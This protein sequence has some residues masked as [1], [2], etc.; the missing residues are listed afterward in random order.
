MTIRIF[1][2]LLL[3]QFIAGNL[4]AQN[5]SVYFSDGE[6]DKEPSREVI[7]KPTI[8]MGIGMFSFYGDI[9]DK[10][11]NHA[12]VSK[13]GYDLNVGKPLTSFL[14]I[15]FYILFGTLSSN[16]RSPE[17]NLNFQS[18]IRTGGAI[19]SY[20]FDHLLRKERKVEPYFSV[21]IESFEFLS[22]TDLFDAR[23]N[24]Y[25]YWNDGS[26][27]NMD[28][29]NPLA[30]EA[31]YLQRDYT[32]ETDIRESNIDGFGK[33][34]ERS[35]AIPV[36]AGVKMKLSDKVNFKIGATMHY[37]FTDLV[38]GI[39]A[40]SVDNRAGNSKND[41]FL[42]T[43]FS[44]SYDFMFTKKSK[45]KLN[46]ED[47]EEV[48]FLALEMADADG[49]GIR[50]FIDSCAGTPIG[51]PVD[52]YG[53]PLDDDNDGVPNYK[54][55]E[56]ATVPNVFVTTEGVELT[57]SL[58]LDLYRTYMDS[59]GQFA[60]VSKSK[61]EAE[62]TKKVTASKYSVQ[63]GAYTTGIPP[64]LIN[65]FLSIPD[66]ISTTVND[67][68][69]VYTTGSYTD[70]A[71][72]KKRKNDLLNSGISSAIVVLN[73][74]GKFI[75]EGT[76]AFNSGGTTETK[77]TDG[78]TNDGATSDGKTN[79]GTTNDGA[80][81]DGKISDGTTNDSAT[82]DGKTSDGTTNDGATNDG[83]TSDG[84]TNDGATTDG[85]TS[86]GKTTD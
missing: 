46:E 25:F 37:T 17:R 27:R 68:V 85:K 18:E 41:R 56:L 3:F 55:D 70:V 75:P 44:L 66:I 11:L 10:T 30:S 4:I 72:A 16:E 43:S 61:Y 40:E 8:G 14:D 45:S 64:E 6:I 57:D 13:I 22:K 5:D 82:N 19:L 32:F 78:T 23:G 21:G 67:S 28:Q 49:D 83:K 73:K 71:Q 12:L 74:D 26:I 79:D 35:F 29:N 81:T 47:F 39:S 20:N 80:T 86:N 76:A 53:C 15:N 69:T 54:D 65:K 77:T 36:G 58:I 63:I 62:V 24:K 42:M 50:D 33:Y 34:T 7:F 59:T 48:D 2:I 52:K 38:D 84:T 51:I 1:C 31:V 60:K 9:S